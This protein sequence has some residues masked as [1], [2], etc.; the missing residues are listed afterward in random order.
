MVAESELVQA[1]SIMLAK[2]MLGEAE[3]VERGLAAYSRDLRL[4]DRAAAWD[5]C[6]L[7]PAIALRLLE[8]WDLLVGPLARLDACA[9]GGSRLASATAAAIREEQ[10]AATGGSPPNHLELRTLGYLGLSDLLRF[11]PNLAPL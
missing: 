4:W 6:H 10:A 7:M 8:R 1:A 2:A 3:A 11:R 5:V 9:D